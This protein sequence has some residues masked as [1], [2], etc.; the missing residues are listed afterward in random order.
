MSAE[1]NAAL[2]LRAILTTYGY[3]LPLPPPI[4]IPCLATVNIE[5][6]GA[7]YEGAP[8][9]RDRERSFK[10]TK[11]NSRWLRGGKEEADVFSAR[12]SFREEGSELERIS[13]Y[14]LEP[15]SLS[16]SLFSIMDGG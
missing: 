7:I 6:F 15:S 10:R 2:I 3:L 16:L 8:R 1:T 12:E 9:I 5:F 4:P 11:S 13:R 14:F